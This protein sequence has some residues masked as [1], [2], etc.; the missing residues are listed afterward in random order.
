MNMSLDEFVKKMVIFATAC[1]LSPKMWEVQ[2]FKIDIFGFGDQILLWRK[3][4]EE[5]NQSH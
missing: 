3:Q 5:K 2:G 1:T 4:C